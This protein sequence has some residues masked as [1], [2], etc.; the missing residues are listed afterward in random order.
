MSNFVGSVHRDVWGGSRLGGRDPMES[1]WINIYE[2][3]YR[4][5]DTVGDMIKKINLMN[6]PDMSVLSDLLVDGDYIWLL[7]T[8]KWDENAEI[9]DRTPYCRLM[10]VKPL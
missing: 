9:E 5:S 3:N 10:K 1:S 4:T 8:P 2:Y 6:I 7:S